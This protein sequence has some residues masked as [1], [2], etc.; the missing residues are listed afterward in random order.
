VAG[1]LIV[2]D[3][4]TN[5]RMLRSI[6]ERDAHRVWEAGTVTETFAVLENE[7]APD[8]AI[9]DLRLVEG[10]GVEI[11]RRLRDDPVF[12]PLPV[13]FCSGQPDRSAVLEAAQLGVVGFVTKPIDPTRVRAGVNKALGARWLR[14]HFDDP[15]AVGQ[16]L[17]TDREKIAEMVAD[18]FR[19]LATM[20]TL[21]IESEDERSAAERHLAALRK[22][23]EEL[24]L[25][26]LAPAL[27]QWGQAKLSDRAVPPLLRRGPVLAR[28]Y[29]A[30]VI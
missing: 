8:L 10:S 15:V 2:D 13:L 3:E 12:K 28:L 26:L 14:A 30:F 20:I 29:A 17:S 5:R 6:L 16:R 21:V 7:A 24:G 25:H 23:A 4:T 1:I 22:T 11:L 27:A 19:E 18:F 9:L